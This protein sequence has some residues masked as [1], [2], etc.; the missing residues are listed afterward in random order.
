MDKIILK[1]VKFHGHHGIKA[2]EKAKGA[3]YLVDVVI[4]RGLSAASRSDFLGATVDYSEIAALILK[5]GKGQSVNLSET[6]AENIAKA[7]LEKFRVK[8][9]DVKVMKVFNYKNAVDKKMNS[10]YSAG[11]EITRRGKA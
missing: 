11:V 5:V 1:G 8:S 4:E 3:D 6:L 10:I 7:I 2:E 9:V